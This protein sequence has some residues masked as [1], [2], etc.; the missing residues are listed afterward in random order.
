M[1]IKIWIGKEFKLWQFKKKVK[2]D[3]KRIF[4]DGELVSDVEDYI[5]KE[6]CSE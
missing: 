1:I 5:I 3:G 4:L 2:F 6:V